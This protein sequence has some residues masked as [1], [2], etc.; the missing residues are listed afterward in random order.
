MGRSKP[1]V[2]GERRFY[3]KKEAGDFVR[4]I[5]YRYPIGQCVADDDA[6][7]LADLLALHPEAPLKI[8]CG[9]RFFSVEQNECSRGFWL[10]RTDGSR[11][12][13]SF[14]SC[15]TPPTPETEA[16]AGFRTAIRPQVAEFRA[17]FES[18]PEQ[19]RC[20]ITGDVLTTANIHIDHETTF[21]DLL[22]SFLRE[23][24]LALEEISVKPTIDGSTTTELA[25]D[26]LKL[27]WADFHRRNARLRA[28]S[29]RAN[30]SILR[31]RNKPLAFET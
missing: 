27:Q 18:A 14:L 22:D 13:W 26:N 1:I 7:F 24:G 31:L 12:D 19:R 8:G 17:Q 28:V 15:L 21:E 11:T 30:L 5:L 25:N 6:E 29:V 2:V 9:V 16:R 23:S 4:S 20:P 10:T 3:S